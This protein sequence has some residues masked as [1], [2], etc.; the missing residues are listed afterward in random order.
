[1]GG[2]YDVGPLRQVA[3]NLF[4]GWGY[5]FYRKENQLRADD[6]LV[7][8]KACWLLGLSRG[9]VE[10][11]EAAYRRE[12]LPPPSRA[13]PY[14]D[15]AAVAGAQALERLSKAIGST[16]AQIR[17]QPVP[18][19]DR[20]TQRYRQEAPTLVALEECDQDLI[21]QA[22]LLRTLVDGRTGEAIVETL[23]DLEHG[24]AAIADTLHRRQA[25]LFGG[26]PA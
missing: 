5:N 21:G 2:F 20:M 19:T 26:G 10:S 13:N 11:A 22:D 1:M 7:R 16:E 14:P 8:A 25:V 23:P 3:I 24:L 18:E 4:Y 6:Q 17:N 15:P 12:H 9:A